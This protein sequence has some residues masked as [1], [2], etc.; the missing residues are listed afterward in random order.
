MEEP[1][2]VVP[3]LIKY[4]FLEKVLLFYLIAIP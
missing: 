1:L 2:S 4:G 3:D